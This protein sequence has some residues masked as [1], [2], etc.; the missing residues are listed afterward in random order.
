V[1][2]AQIP[3]P[4]AGTRIGECVLNAYKGVILPPYSGELEV[5]TWNVSLKAPK[6]AEKGKKKK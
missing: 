5:V 4:F 6:P 1:A 2:E 3:A